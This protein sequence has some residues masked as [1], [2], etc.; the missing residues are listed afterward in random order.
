MSEID[1]C[2]HCGKLIVW[3]SSNAVWRHADVNASSWYCMPDGVMKAEP[4]G[5]CLAVTA[6]RP[7]RR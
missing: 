2:R 6:E 4:A 1:T 5:D 7:G 3:N